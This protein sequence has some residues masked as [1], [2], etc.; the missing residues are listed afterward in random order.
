MGDERDLSM[1]FVSEERL[2]GG[3]LVAPIL[4]GLISLAIMAV[5]GTTAG[6][7]PAT[8]GALE[9]MA[10]YA[11]RLES[12]VLMFVL[13]WIVHLLGI[14]LLARLLA[15]DGAGQLAIVAFSLILVTVISAIVKFS[16][17]MTVELWAAQEMARG[18]A[19][20]RLYEPLS[21][22]TSS[23]FRVGYGIH[24]V[25]M[26]AIGWAIVRTGL[27]AASLGWATIAWSALWLIAG[28]VGLGIPAVPLLMPA[29]IGLALLWS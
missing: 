27:L 9:A 8:Q 26:I 10:P 22:W 19:V 2:A 21:N 29:V 16:F 17:D 6:Y 3:L 13:I 7:Q 11:D 24:F 14:G 5:S 1:A 20:P 12:N 25:A 18:G 28:L 4:I 15:R 23:V